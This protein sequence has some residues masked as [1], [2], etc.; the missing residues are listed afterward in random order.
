MESMHAKKG[1][2]KCL[3]LKNRIRESDIRIGIYIWNKIVMTI[4]IVLMLSH[5]LSKRE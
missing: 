1:F 5:L 2:L 4:I 3:Y